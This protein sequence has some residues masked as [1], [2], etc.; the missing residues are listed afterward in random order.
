MIRVIIL[1]IILTPYAS[2]IWHFLAIFGFVSMIFLVLGYGFYSYISGYDS[3]RKP[4][5][6]TSASTLR[7]Q[8]LRKQ[9]DFLLRNGLHPESLPMTPK[10]RSSP[11]PSNKSPVHVAI[12]SFLRDLLKNNL[13]QKESIKEIITT[14]MVWKAQQEHPGGFAS[15]K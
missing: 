14:F 6:M 13:L 5:V 11:V 15:K 12:S 2:T 8:G 9:Y 4:L 10:S 1:T 3:A 7:Y